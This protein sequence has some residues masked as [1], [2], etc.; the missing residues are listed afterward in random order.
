MK[1]FLTGGTGFIGSYVV[2]ELINQ[3]HEITIL[4]RNPK[5]VSGFINHNAI[6]LVKGTLYDNDIIKKALKDKDACIHIA[7]GWGDTAINMLEKDTKVSV[8]L[9]E[10]AAELGVK[11]MI[12][13]SS[14]AA[15]GDLRVDMDESISPRPID[16]YGAT[17][18]ATEA[19]LLSIARAYDIQANIIRPGYTFGNPVVE[20]SYMQPDT[21]FW[22]IVNLAKN[23]KDIKL[24]KNDGTQFIWAGDL[25][26]V[27][28]AVLNSEYNR[29]I[30]FGLSNEFVTWEEIAQLALDYTNSSS[31]IILEDKAWGWATYRFDL[32]K[33]DKE[34]GFNFTCLDH[35][36]SH[37][38]YLA[39]L[40]GEYNA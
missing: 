14:T 5:K 22:D 26:K 32:D 34:F 9:M 36:K 37:L 7:L 8:Y 17:K 15:V 4:A 35:I 18:A 40:K 3:G 39:E 12:Y 38:A 23:N 20:G 31:Q 27:Y 24:V 2:N 25:A 11:K 28:S 10:T 29:E 21:R 19:Y 6:Q 33:L 30:F 13:T 1:V 16:F